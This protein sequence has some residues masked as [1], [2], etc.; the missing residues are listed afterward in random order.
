MPKVAPYGTPAM[1]GAAMAERNKDKRKERINCSLNVF[2][3]KQGQM[4]DEKLA[5]IF[6]IP[7]GT[8]KARR[9]DPSSYT[10]REVWRMIEVAAQ[11]GETI[12]FGL[13]EIA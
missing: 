1:K 13:E 12:D 9:K 3:A 4:S 10:L 8:M 2:K 6:G 7:Y 5:E 11:Y